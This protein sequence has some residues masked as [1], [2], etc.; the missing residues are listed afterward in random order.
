MGHGAKE[1]HIFKQTIFD[2][3]TEHFILPLEHHVDLNSLP[4]I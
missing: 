2:I 3:Y 4:M 1:A